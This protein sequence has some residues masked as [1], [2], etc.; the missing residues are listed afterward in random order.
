LRGRKA[1]WAVLALLVA[2]APAATSAGTPPR[3]DPCKGCVLALHYPASGPKSMASVIANR[4]GPGRHH[5]RGFRKRT[6]VDGYAAFADC[7]HVTRSEVALVRI[8]NPTAR[9]W[10]RTL[11]LEAADCQAP[12]DR[13]ALA[14]RGVEVEVD[15]ATAVRAGF[16]WTGRS[17]WGTTWAQIVGFVR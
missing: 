13:P 8:W 10:T 7:G 4:L 14:R 11:R 12:G 2:L 17:G 16:Y 15:A 9:S 6:D 3:P 1:V 5:T